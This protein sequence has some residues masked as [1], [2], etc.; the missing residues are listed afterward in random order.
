MSGNRRARTEL[1]GA[2]LGERA[3]ISSKRRTRADGG[4]EATKKD[5]CDGMRKFF[6]HLRTVIGHR[7]LVLKYCVKAGIPWQGLAHDLSK[8]S[9]VEFRNGVKY[10]TDGKHSPTVEER[11]HD[12]FS[13]AWLHHKGRNKHH[14]EYWTEFNWDNRPICVC[15]MPVRYVKEMFCD[16]LAATK[17]YLKSA[18]SDFAPLEYYLSRDERRFMHRDASALL[19][20]ALILLA[21][22]GENA[23][24]RFLKNLKNRGPYPES[25][26]E[27]PLC[28]P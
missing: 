17:T 1:A 11:R 4:R 3:D 12:G 23:A 22:S 16:R 20:R 27:R 6:G 5:R 25:A 24:L 2:R 9:R 28:R 21:T 14:F 19:E 15:K 10:Y 7:R 8:F 26:P 13:A 18:Y